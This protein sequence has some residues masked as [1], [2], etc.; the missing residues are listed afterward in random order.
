MNKYLYLYKKG[1]HPDTATPFALLDYDE[2]RGGGYLG[3]KSTLTKLGLAEL[4]I[5]DDG[6]Q[7]FV[8]VE[9]G[10]D[11]LRFQANERETALQVTGLADTAAQPGA[12]PPGFIRKENILKILDEL[13]ATRKD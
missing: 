6:L 13:G 8:P 5:W 12:A 2:Q 4:E 1:S 7:D 9:L 3:S 10:K 11:G